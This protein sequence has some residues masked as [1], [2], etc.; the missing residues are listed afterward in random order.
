MQN[1]TPVVSSTSPITLHVTFPTLDWPLYLLL[2]QHLECGVILVKLFRNNISTTKNGFSFSYPSNNNQNTR[3]RFKFKPIPPPSTH[4]NSFM[5]QN[6]LSNSVTQNCTANMCGWSGGTAMGFAE[7]RPQT[8]KPS[9]PKTPESFKMKSRNTSKF[10]CS[11]ECGNCADGD[12]GSR[13]SYEILWAGTN[14]MV[15]LKHFISGS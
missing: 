2:Q 11:F 12:C 8:R 9:I 1:C 13:E 5:N 10:Y 15:R 14:K 6:S 7:W 3:S 4:D